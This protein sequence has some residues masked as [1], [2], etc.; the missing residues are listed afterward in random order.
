[1]LSLAFRNRSG[2]RYHCVIRALADDPPDG[3]VNHERLDDPVRVCRLL[4]HRRSALTA[5]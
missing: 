5:V 1:M 3:V 4:D 2:L